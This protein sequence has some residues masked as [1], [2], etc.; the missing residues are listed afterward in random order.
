[1]FDPA[2]SKSRDFYGVLKSSLATESRGFIKLKSKFSIDDME[3]KKRLLIIIRSCICETYVQF[4]QFKILND[5]LFT[6]SRL[7]KIGGSRVCSVINFVHKKPYPNSLLRKGS[8]GVGEMDSL[9]TA[10]TA[11]EHER[12]L[13]AGE[14]YPK[15]ITVI[16]ISRSN[17]Q[18]ITLQRPLA[19]K[20]YKMP[21]LNFNRS[22]VVKQ[23]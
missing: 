5:I 4:F 7:A 16:A 20:R 21:Q 10:Y 3:T 13:C 18:V 14:R 23:G 12:G 2:L 9:R 1:M 17:I 11:N 19:D 8:Q 6:N 15:K 22:K